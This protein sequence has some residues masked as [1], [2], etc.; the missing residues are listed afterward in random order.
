MGLVL[1]VLEQVQ[2][3]M[4]LDKERHL[5]ILLNGPVSTYQANAKT[6][7]A[8]IPKATRWEDTLFKENLAT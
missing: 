4:S 5:G 6:R 8:C 1:I 2:Q 3:K 7:L